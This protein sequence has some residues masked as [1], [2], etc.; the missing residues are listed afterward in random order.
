MLEPRKHSKKIV[1][2]D[3]YKSMTEGI[4]DTLA[5]FGLLEAY[6]QDSESDQKDRKD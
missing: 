6:D 2:D 4:R 5:E 1:Q 3:I